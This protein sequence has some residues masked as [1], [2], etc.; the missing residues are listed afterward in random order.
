MTDRDFVEERRWERIC[1]EYDKL[2]A[3]MPAAVRA[4]YMQNPILRMMFDRSPGYARRLAELRKRIQE[5]N[6]DNILPHADD[7]PRNLPTPQR[8]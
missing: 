3:R 6:K 7:P 1:A 8:S 5:E 2:I 4:V